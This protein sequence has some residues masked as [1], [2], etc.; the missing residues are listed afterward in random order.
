MLVLSLSPLPY[1]TL[2]DPITL[3]SSMCLPVSAASLSYVNQQWVVRVLGFSFNIIITILV[4]LTL[5]YID[6]N[7][8]SSHM[9]FF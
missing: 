6:V 5:M 7:L 2:P 8:A 9:D 1:L 4:F 3:M